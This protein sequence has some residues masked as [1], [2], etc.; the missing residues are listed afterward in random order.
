MTIHASYERHPDLGCEAVVFIDDESMGC[1]QIQRDLV[2][3]AKAGGRE[4]YCVTT[5]ASAPVYGG[6]VEWRRVDDDRIEFAL[7]PKAGRLFGDNVL[8][9]QITPVG[10]ESVDEIIEHVERLLR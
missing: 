8:S 10:D 6:V 7:T 9:F 2:S 3:D 1:F 4:G 5:G